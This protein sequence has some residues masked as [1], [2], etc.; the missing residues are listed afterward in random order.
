VLDSITHT[1]LY[2]SVGIGSSGSGSVGSGSGSSGSVG[3][4]YI[5]H[6]KLG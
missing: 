3:R 6:P 1:L 4:S 5:I 2:G